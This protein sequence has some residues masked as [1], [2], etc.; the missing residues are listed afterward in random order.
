M[1]KDVRILVLFIIALLL[2]S[3]AVYLRFVGPFENHLET[4][5]VSE[6]KMN[7]TIYTGIII[8]F[9]VD[10]IDWGSG[11][12]RAGYENATLSTSGINFLEKVV[13]GNWSGAYTNKTEG[14]IIENIGNVDVTINLKT[15]LNASGFIGGSEPLYQFN[16]TNNMT[17][18]CSNSSGFNLGQ[19]YDVNISGEGARVC[20]R[21]TYNA[22][23]K[24]RVDILLRIPR[25]SNLGPLH[26][27]V[28]ATAAVS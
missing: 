23:N 25:D 7:L 8:N 14:F 12:V 27:K 22:Q 5:L 18:S 20:D 28:T 2:T 19:W 26:D 10:V 4:G 16:V 13:G 24:I 21:L 17:G 11:K 9:S 3:L 6:S 1:A 15:G